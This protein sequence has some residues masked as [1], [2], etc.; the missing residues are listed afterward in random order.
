MFRS[1]LIAAVALA[2]FAPARATAQ[3]PFDPT[4]AGFR[5][6]DAKVDKDKLTWAEV[7]YISQVKEVER[8]VNVN[9]MNVTQKVAF[10]VV[11]PVVQTV[12]Y[13]LKKLKVDTLL[14]RRYERLRT[15][16]S[17]FVDLS[18]D[19]KPAAATPRAP[20]TRKTAART[21]PAQV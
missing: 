4:P 14:K 13:E 11:V 3:P 7:K 2:V 18:P 20:R 8:I 10:T 6:V 12:G 5:V 1:A 9:G 17:F 19:A 21:T 16:G 15:L